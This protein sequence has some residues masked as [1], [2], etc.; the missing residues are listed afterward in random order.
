[1]KEDLTRRELLGMLYSFTSSEIK[2]A[3]M[4]SRDRYVTGKYFVWV[5]E[6]VKI[7]EFLYDY[8]ESL[9]NFGNKF[10][11]EDLKVIKEALIGIKKMVLHDVKFAVDV[12]L[13]LTR[14]TLSLDAVA[15]DTLS[16]SRYEYEY[17]P[18]APVDKT[19]ERRFLGIRR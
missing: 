16:K 13:Y 19:K 4:N 6:L 7:A 8:E 9:K 12:Y 18:P 10:N 1:M 17:A 15:F 5:R 14:S 2:L 11:K 3:N